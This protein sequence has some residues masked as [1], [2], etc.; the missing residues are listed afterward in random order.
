MSGE[1]AVLRAFRKEIQRAIPVDPAERLRRELEKAVHDERYED[2]ARLR[3][4]LHK[5][6][7]ANTDGGE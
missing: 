4:E 7:H 2:A 6:Q 5:L 3:D 1:L